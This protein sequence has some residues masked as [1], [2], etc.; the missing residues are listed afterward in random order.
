[1]QALSRLS[2]APANGII[3]QIHSVRKGFDVKTFQKE[4]ITKRIICALT[5]SP[6]FSRGEYVKLDLVTL[7]LL[8]VLVLLLSK[9]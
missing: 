4:G 1:M 6:R 7:L 8:I 9:K 2:Y 5:Y 3:A